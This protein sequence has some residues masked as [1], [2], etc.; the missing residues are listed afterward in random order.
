MATGLCQGLRRL[1]WLLRSATAPGPRLSAPGG[2][3]RR[4][5]AKVLAGQEPSNP[6]G[7]RSPA[8]PPF[9]RVNTHSHGGRASGRGRALRAPEGNRNPEPGTRSRTEGHTSENAMRDVRNR[10]TECQTEART[11]QCTGPRPGWRLFRKVRYAFPDRVPQVPR[12]EERDCRV[13]YLRREQR[14]CRDGLLPR[15][16]ARGTGAMR[17]FSLRKPAIP[18]QFWH[19]SM[20]RTSPRAWESAV[21]NRLP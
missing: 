13:S 8:I 20:G 16:Q 7:G 21:G 10:Q 19:I 6:E 1:P 18:G 15:I 17:R 5:Q 2:R 9:R 14:P 4:E 3:P 11:G 12:T